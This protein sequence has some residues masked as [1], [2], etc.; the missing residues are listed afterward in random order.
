[1]SIVSD[2]NSTQMC[3]FSG[4]PELPPC[5]D[6]TETPKEET[7]A[8]KNKTNNKEKMNQFIKRQMNDDPIDVMMDIIEENKRLRK[9][10]ERIRLM[11]YFDINTEDSSDIEDE[12]EVDEIG[13]DKIDE[14]V[15]NRLSKIKEGNKIQEVHHQIFFYYNSLN[16]ILGKQGTGKT[17]FIMKEL[18]KMN[19]I[20]HLYGAVIYVS[21]SAG[22]D[23]TFKE[24]KDL[25]KTPIYG[26]NYEKFMPTLIQYYKQPQEKHLLIILEDALFALMKEDKTWGE[27]ITR[28]RHL[29]TTIIVNMH[30]W[31]SLNPSFK[32]QVA[33]IIIFKGYSKENFNYIFRQ[34]AA[35]T[36]GFIG[37]YLYLGMNKDQLLKIDN[38]TG[39]IS[40]IKK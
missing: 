14:I 1:M 4:A 15:N 33:T 9:E 20:E 8:K 32:T 37:Y 27:I 3:S 2:T 31:K 16:I 34:T 19:K 5:P 23:E 29:K 25:I 12:S 30:I 6:I 39:D 22:E 36:S 18:I 35:N 26:M 40:V 28:L 13:I 24:L 38:L 7:K 11:N 21:Q 10:L 17:T